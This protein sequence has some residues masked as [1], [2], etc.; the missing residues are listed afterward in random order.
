MLWIPP[1]SR[2][3]RPG[4]V[5]GS[6]ASAR[7]RWW[8]NKPGLERRR[9]CTA[10]PRPANKLIRLGPRHQPVSV[11]RDEDGLPDRPRGQATPSDNPICS[12]Y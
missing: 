5:C 7:F 8:W 12:A 4:R 11:Y 2:C 3:T 6:R 10:S 9:N 1:A